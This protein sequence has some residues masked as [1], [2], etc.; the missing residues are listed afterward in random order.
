MNDIFSSRVCMYAGWG[1]AEMGGEGKGDGAVQCFAKGVKLAR[2][3][4][5]L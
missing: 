3:A 5:E 2:T 4:S 1:G